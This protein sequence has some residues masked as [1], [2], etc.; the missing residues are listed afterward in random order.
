M[1]SRDAVD[2]LEAERNKRGGESASL[3][4]E[5]IIHECRRRQDTKNVDATISAYYDSLSNEERE[6]DKR[7]GEFAESQFPMD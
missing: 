3:V 2:F 1:L 6:E 5:E 7:W 4:L